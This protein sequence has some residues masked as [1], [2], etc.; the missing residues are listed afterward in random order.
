MKEEPYCFMNTF[1]YCF[2]I[3]LL[4]LQVYDQALCTTFK[5]RL[6]KYLPKFLNITLTNLAQQKKHRNFTKCPAVGGGGGWGG[7]FGTFQI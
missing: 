7:R 4:A 2:A 1:C 3:K 5:K 6:L